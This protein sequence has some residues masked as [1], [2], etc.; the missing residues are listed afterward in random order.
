[1]V[2]QY[3]TKTRPNLDVPFFEDCDEGRDR[4][5]AIIQLS[6]DHPELVTSRDSMARPATELVWTATWTFAGLEEYN[7]FLQLAYNY[8]TTL[9]ID[10]TR[11]YMTNEHTLLIEHK[12]L[13]T[14][15]VTLVNVTPTGVTDIDGNVTTEI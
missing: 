5:D 13:N 4:S 6:I 10:R 8:D 11:Y 7:T 3:I 14:D 15:R 1:M 2:E 12:I 9:R